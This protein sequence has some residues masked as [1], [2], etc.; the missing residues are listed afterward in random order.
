VGEGTNTDVLS[1]V[2]G[3]K[4]SSV[5][6]YGCLSHPSEG[7][8]LRAFWLFFDAVDGDLYAAVGLQALGELQRGL[9]AFAL[10]YRVCGAFALGGHGGFDALAE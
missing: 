5:P 3:A 10:D 9:F 1:P 7:A 6:R 4:I 2:C 8:L